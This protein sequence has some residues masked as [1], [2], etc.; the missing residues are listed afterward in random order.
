MT[1]LLSSLLKCSTASSCVFSLGAALKEKQKAASEHS[2]GEKMKKAY[3]LM[4][5]I[6]DQV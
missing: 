6:P 4:Q 2:I 5:K 1:G 3:Y